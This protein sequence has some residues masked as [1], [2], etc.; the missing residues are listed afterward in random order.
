MTCGNIQWMD[1]LKILAGIIGWFV[2]LRSVSRIHA[3]RLRNG[4]A[5][6]KEVIPFVIGAVGM[7]VLLL[8]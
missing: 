4:S 8:A 5:N 7:I 2:L 3:F 6:W 1:W